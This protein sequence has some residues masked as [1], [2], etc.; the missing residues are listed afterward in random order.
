MEIEPTLSAG[1][2]TTTRKY[3]YCLVVGDVECDWDYV[4]PTGRGLLQTV[5]PAPGNDDR[6]A[7]VVKTMG[8][9]FTD[10]RAAA[11]S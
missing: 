9:R 2:S 3:L 10:A 11:H 5:L 7:K 6:V 1:C 4:R 8:K